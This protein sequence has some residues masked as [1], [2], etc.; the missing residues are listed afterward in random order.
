MVTEEEKYLASLEAEGVELDE[1]PE[2]T[3][4]KTDPEPEKDAEPEKPVTEP[5]TEDEPEVDPKKKPEEDDP[6]L[7]TKKPENHKRSIY[8]DLKDRKKEVKTEKERADLAERERDELQAKLDAV[9]KAQDEGKSSAHAEDDLET[10]LE[11]HQVDPVVA[12]LLI[13]EARKGLKP[14]IDESL[15]NDIAEF[16]AWKQDNRKVIESQA[17]E[18]EFITSLPAIK[19]FFPTA[20]ES[21]LSAIKK[22]LDTISHTK[23]WHDK[24]LKYIAFEHKDTLS[25]LITPRKRG[26]ESRERKDTTEV[27]N[28]FNPTPDFGKMT[29]KEIEAW[30]K[31]YREAG[32]N[33]GLIETASGKKIM[34]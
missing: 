2:K 14:E 25:A 3:E 23:E 26:M 27:E 16:K 20:T 18:T 11:E 5:E 28:D 31:Q 13:A 33:D 30:E 17:F 4:D 15:K 21:E 22:E 24:S 34:L 12:E 1:V 19:E 7:Q 29:T 6:T 10:F 8:D 9:S 32:R